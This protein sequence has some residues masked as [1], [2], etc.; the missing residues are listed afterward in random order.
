MDYLSIPHL[1]LF[2]IMSAQMW[3]SVPFLDT[4][5]HTHTHTKPHRYTTLLCEAEFTKFQEFASQLK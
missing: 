4:H 5:T 3:D 1:L 2:H